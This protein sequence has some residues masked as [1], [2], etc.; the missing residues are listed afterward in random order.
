MYSSKEQSPIVLLAQ[1]HSVNQ[2]VMY[3]EKDETSKWECQANVISM[4]D[5]NC[6]STLCSDK[7]CQDTKFIN[8]QPVKPAMKK[9]SHMQLA[10]LAILQSDYKIK[11]QM[12][13]LFVCDDKN[14]QSMQHIHICPVK[15]AM[16]R[17]SHM[18]LA[19]PAMLQ[20]HYKKKNQMKQVFVCDDKTVNLPNNT[21]LKSI[22]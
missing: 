1:G 16:K 11:N 19:K 7:N 20:S 9:S 13:Q 3:E 22:H 18:W 4:D 6:Q 8:M 15:P 10:K 14:C 12:K 2:C 21:V 17:S 5:K